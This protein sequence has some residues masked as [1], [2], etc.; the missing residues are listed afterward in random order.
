MVA[1]GASPSI[2]KLESSLTEKT[3]LYRAK[4]CEDVD[5]EDSDK[6]REVE[7]DC[8]T[9]MSLAAHHHRSRSSSLASQKRRHITKRSSAKV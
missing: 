2:E 5:T 8:I 1:R 6:K 3:A 9:R 4:F 7:E